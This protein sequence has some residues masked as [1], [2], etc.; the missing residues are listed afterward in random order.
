MGKD[1][2]LGEELKELVSLDSGVFA[3]EPNENAALAMIR[4]RPYD[5]VLLDADALTLDAAK[6]IKRIRDL[7][8]APL[9]IISSARDEASAIRWLDMGADGYMT[10]PLRMGELGARMRSAIRFYDRLV[11]EDPENG[12]MME[13]CGIRLDLKKR[14]V[15]VREGEKRFTKKEFDLLLYLMQ[16]PGKVFSREELYAAVWNDEAVGGMATVTVHIKKLREA[17]ELRAD[18]PAIIMTEWG[19]GYYFNNDRD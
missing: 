19:R 15:W 12:T 17:V 8:F 11:P 5:L 16:H 1:R 7:S 4:E 3:M 10:K 14:R 9:F 2:E 18:R 6:L 13:A